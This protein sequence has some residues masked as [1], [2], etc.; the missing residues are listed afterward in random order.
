MIN[1]HGADTIRTLVRFPKQSSGV[2]PSGQ[3]NPAIW[4]QET[5]ETAGEGSFSRVAQSLT[6]ESV[7]YK[8]GK[9]RKRILNGPLIRNNDRYAFLNDSAPTSGEES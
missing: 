7:N 4:A 8:P 5:V 1:F 2:R 6:T 3:F 9:L